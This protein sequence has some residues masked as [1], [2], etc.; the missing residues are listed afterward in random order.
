MYK[1]AGEILGKLRINV[2]SI[3]GAVDNLSGGQRQSVAVGRAVAWG[4]TSC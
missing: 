3:R 2:P 1:E 4:V